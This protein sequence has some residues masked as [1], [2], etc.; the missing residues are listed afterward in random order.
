MSSH[1]TI[2]YVLWLIVAKIHQILLVDVAFTILPNDFHIVKV[3]NSLC[4]VFQD[5]Y[6]ESFA[7]LFTPKKRED[8][9]NDI[10]LIVFI[11]VSQTLMT[12][13][14]TLAILAFFNPIF[15]SLNNF[16]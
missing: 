13:L 6:H 12:L 9:I 4:P 15:L 2:G 8:F 14:L 11:D 7:F 1:N 3:E 5:P 16:F 10:R